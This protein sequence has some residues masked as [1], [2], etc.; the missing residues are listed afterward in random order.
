[1]LLVNHTG[2]TLQLMMLFLALTVSQIA[3]VSS[4]QLFLVKMIN[5]P[6]SQMDSAYQKPLAA[7]EH[8]IVKMVQMKLVV[9]V[10]QL[11]N[12]PVRLI[13]D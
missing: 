6:V 5:S 10:D 12:K 4:L 1:M 8:V 3:A 11:E 13:F 2:V 7:T 9:V